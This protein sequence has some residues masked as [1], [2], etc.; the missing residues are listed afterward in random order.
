MPRIASRAHTS[1]FRFLL[2]G[3]GSGRLQKETGQNDEVNGS[4]NSEGRI[5]HVLIKTY[6]QLGEYDAS[7]RLN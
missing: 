1:D 6:K 4:A 5:G 3:Q 2:S 7:E